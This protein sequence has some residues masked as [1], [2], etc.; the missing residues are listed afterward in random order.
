MQ[1]NCDM[2][3]SSRS[4]IYLDQSE[5]WNETFYSRITLKTVAKSCKPSCGSSKKYV[6]AQLRCVQTD[7]CSSSDKS[8]TTA[9]GPCLS[10]KGLEVLWDRCPAQPELKSRIHGSENFLAT[11][12]AYFEIKGPPAVRQPH[13]WCTNLC[14][15]AL[16]CSTPHWPFRTSSYP[17]R[18]CSGPSWLLSSR[19][20]RYR[21]LEAPHL[22]I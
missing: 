21:W 10:Q 17:C 22:V 14:S 4:S 15:T 2:P 18:C 20:G 5:T 11:C 3:S 13:R 1:V 7:L 19:M 9:Q 12:S 16:Q 8:Y 6:G